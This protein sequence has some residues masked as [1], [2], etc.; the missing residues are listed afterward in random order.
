[1]PCSEAFVKGPDIYL[2]ELGIVLACVVD[3]DADAVIDASHRIFVNWEAYYVSSEAALVRFNSEPYR[4]TGKVTDPVTKER[5]FPGE[6]SPTR[7]H[8][9]RLFYFSSEETAAQFDTDPDK[10]A[11]P[12]ISMRPAR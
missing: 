2:N 8:S 12:M 10:M 9:E 4:F 6:G 1:V 7:K 5:F 3:P 11:V